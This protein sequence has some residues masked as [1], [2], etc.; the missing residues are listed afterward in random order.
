MS[1]NDFLTNWNSIYFNETLVKRY[2]KPFTPSDKEKGEKCPSNELIREIDGASFYSLATG[3]DTALEDLF[4]VLPDVISECTDGQYVFRSKE[5]LK[6][7]FKQAY[8]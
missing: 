4:D 8:K 3:S 7:F 5:K 6:E 1:K 2:N